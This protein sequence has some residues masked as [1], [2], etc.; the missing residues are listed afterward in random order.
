M[1][2]FKNLWKNEP[3]MVVAAI[4]AVIALA[5]SFGLELSPGQIGALLAA[6]TTVA[7]LLI[8]SQVSSVA[9]LKELDSTTL[10]KKINQGYTTLMTVLIVVAIILGLVL[11]A[12]FVDVNVK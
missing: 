1:E 5:V 8:R 6:F 4:N 12:K 10:V 3:T 9:A 11:L 7:G 2:T